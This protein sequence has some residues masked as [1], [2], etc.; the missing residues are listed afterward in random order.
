MAPEQERFEFLQAAGATATARF[1]KAPLKSQSLHLLT[2]FPTFCLSIDW[3]RSQQN[4][5]QFFQ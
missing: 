3:T 5:L 4:A 1:F 2:R